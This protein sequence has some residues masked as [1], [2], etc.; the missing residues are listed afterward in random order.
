[1]LHGWINTVKLLQG[2]RKIEHRLGNQNQF[3]WE[4]LKIIEFSIFSLPEEGLKK[5]PED[6]K[7]KLI[8][9]PWHEFFFDLKLCFVNFGPFGSPMQLFQKELVDWS[10][11]STSNWPHFSYQIILRSLSLA[12]LRHLGHFDPLSGFPIHFS[13]RGGG[14]APLPYGGGESIR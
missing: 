4:G 12:L 11:G 2:L 3:I 7:W 5:L 14:M 13:T 8:N 6:G 9:A 10:N 1:M